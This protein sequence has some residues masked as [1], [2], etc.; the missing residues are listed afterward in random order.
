VRLVLSCSWMLRW[1]WC[2][3]TWVRAEEILSTVLGGSVDAAGAPDRLVLACAEALP[4]T[5]VGLALMTEAGHGGTVAV[6]DARARTMEELQFTSGEGP[7]VECSDT[8]RPVLQP[9]LART[10]PGRWPGFS[11]SA[12]GVGIRAVFAL[13]LRVGAIRVGALDL[14]RDTA[15]ELTDAELNEA[16]SFADAATQI[17]L[18]LQSRAPLDGAGTSMVPLLEDRAVVHQATGMIAVQ[19]GVGM[20]EALIRLR[21]RAYAA[22]RPIVDLAEEVV[23]GVVDFAEEDGDQGR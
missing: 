3:V 10:G 5:G 21:A 17:L 4:V 6:S 22:E 12:V 2:P 1:W 18:H 16:L 7:C 23:D 11:E 14:Y 20:A 8:G 19:A 13:P 9:D 15:G